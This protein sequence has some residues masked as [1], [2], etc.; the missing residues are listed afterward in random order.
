M[1]FEIAIAGRAAGETI[2]DALP[3]RTCPL[4]PLGCGWEL[5]DGN[6]IRTL[7]PTAVI[8]LLARGGVEGARGSVQGG[9]GAV[10]AAAAGFTWLGRRDLPLNDR[11]FRRATRIHQ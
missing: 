3:L 8:S 6:S 10:Q 4:G 5:T 11:I 1:L 2:G 7:R 9:E